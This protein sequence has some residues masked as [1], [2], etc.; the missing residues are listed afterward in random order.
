MGT[1]PGRGA[2]ANLRRLYVVGYS[3]EHGGLLLS[4]RTGARTGTHVLEIDDSVLDELERAGRRRASKAAGPTRG[5]DQSALTPREMQARL[6]AGES[7]EEV[8]AEAGVGVDWVERFANPVLAELAAAVD[9]ARDAVLHSVDAGP[10][11]HP[12]GVSV[13]QNLASRGIILDDEEFRSGWS[14]RHLFGPEWCVSFRYRSRGRELSAEWTLNSQSGAIG[15]RNSSGEE[16]GHSGSRPVTA[17]TPRS[18]PARTESLAP[19]DDSPTTTP[20][21]GAA[22]TAPPTPPAGAES[23]GSGE[24]AQSPVAGGAAGPAGPVG[25]VAAVPTAGVGEVAVAV[26]VAPT[27]GVSEVGEV[28]EVAEAVG[29]E[30]LVDAPP[31]GLVEAGAPGAPARN[32]RRRRPHAQT[33]LPLIDRAGTPP[34]V[35][36]AD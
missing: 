4:T 14:A 22:Q 20:P 3:A 24:V 33:S 2:S 18:R 5:G 27:G 26:S 36:A 21:S 11:D 17:R 23:A 7:I 34:P 13:R 29:P 12:L 30:G 35:G 32:E 8:A 25:L 28:G 1:S 6:R 19:P 10:S 15:A 31:E 9:R 16:L